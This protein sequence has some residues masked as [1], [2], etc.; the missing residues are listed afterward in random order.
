MSDYPR[1]PKITPNINDSSDTFTVGPPG[2]FGATAPTKTV[3]FVKAGAVNG[4]AQNA[5]GI[6]FISSFISPMLQLPFGYGSS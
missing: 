3:T 1:F 5:P 6:P 4:G 2:N